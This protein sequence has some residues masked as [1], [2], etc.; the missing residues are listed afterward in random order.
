VSLLVLV[1]ALVVLLGCYQRRPCVASQGSRRLPVI[2][3]F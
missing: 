2:G 3:A 1:L